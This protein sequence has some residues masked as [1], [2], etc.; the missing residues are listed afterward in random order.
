MK[1][2]EIRQLN[3]DLIFLINH[4]IESKNNNFYLNY[5]LNKNG[6]RLKAA[7]ES[8]DKLVPDELKIIENKIWAAAVEKAKETEVQATFDLGISVLTDEEAARRLELMND[9]NEVL[10][11]DTDINLYYLNADKCQDINLEFEYVTILNNFI[12]E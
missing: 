11:Q 6:Q 3:T 4:C 12:K 10:Q 2:I 1:N 7:I 9:F 8:I 5:A